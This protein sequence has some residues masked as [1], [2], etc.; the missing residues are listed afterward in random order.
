MKLLSQTKIKNNMFL[1]GSEFRTP[2][3]PKSYPNF[4]Y[5][6]SLLQYPSWLILTFR[7]DLFTSIDPRFFYLRFLPRS[8]IETNIDV[9]TTHLFHICCLL[10]IEKSRTTTKRIDN[11]WRNKKT[12]L[13]T[14]LRCNLISSPSDDLN[15]KRVSFLMN[16]RRISNKWN[17]NHELSFDNKKRPNYVC[18][19]VVLYIYI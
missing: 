9:D 13:L 11:N 4:L 19:F 16:G 15:L 10:S 5:W 6:S 17:R 14:R 1:A 12:F 8:T 18:L 7:L 3:S 2:T